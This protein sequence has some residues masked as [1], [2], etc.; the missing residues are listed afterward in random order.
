MHLVIQRYLKTTQLQGIFTKLETGHLFIN[1][2]YHKNSLDSIHNDQNGKR[3]DLAYIQ[4][5]LLTVALN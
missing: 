2:S 5:T 1:L 4:Q 3:G